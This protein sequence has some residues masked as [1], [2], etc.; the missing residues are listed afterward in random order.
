[1]NLLWKARYKLIML[2]KINESQKRL[3]ENYRELWR[4]LEYVN[5]ISKELDKITKNKIFNINNPNIWKNIFARRNILYIDFYEITSCIKDLLNLMIGN[6][7]RLPFLKIDLKT[8]KKNPRNLTKNFYYQDMINIL[9]EYNKYKDKFKNKKGYFDH[10]LDDI[11]LI[12]KKTKKSRNN[13]A[14]PYGE[15]ATSMEISIND[16][17]SLNKKMK[18]ILDIISIMVD[19]PPFNELSVLYNE[20]KSIE[21]TIDLVLLGNIDQIPWS[22]HCFN[23]DGNFTRCS[24]DFGLNR[25]QFYDMLHRQHSLGNHRRNFNTHHSGV[26]YSA[27]FN[28]FLGFFGE[29]I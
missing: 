8:L 4:D 17:M 24:N 13:I 19:E 16:L 3:Q 7:P 6:I 14:H 23:K 11:N 21:D 22:E 29:N 15:E 25:E 26:Y 1:M 27:P 5:S 2:E 9:N 28:K 12:Q 20:Q 10:L 18:S